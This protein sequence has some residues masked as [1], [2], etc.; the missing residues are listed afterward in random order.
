MSVLRRWLRRRPML[1]EPAPDAAALI[2]QHLGAIRAVVHA[3]EC[4]EQHGRVVAA[5]ATLPGR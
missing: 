1:P 4:D 3:A 2:E 5:G